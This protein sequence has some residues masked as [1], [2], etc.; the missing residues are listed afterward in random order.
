MAE[1][2]FRSLLTSCVSNKRGT[3]IDILRGYPRI[4]YL[5]TGRRRML[6]PEAAHEFILHRSRI[7]ERF[8]NYQQHGRCGWSFCWALGC[9][10][11]LSFHNCPLDHP[12]GMCA[13]V[14]R[15]VGRVVPSCS[16][17]WIGL[18]PHRGSNRRSRRKVV[19]GLASVAL[20]VPL[21]VVVGRTSGRGCDPALGSTQR[22]DWRC[23]APVWEP[24]GFGWA[25][26]HKLGPGRKDEFVGDRLHSTQNPPGGNEGALGPY[27]T[28]AG[29]ELGLAEGE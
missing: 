26:W 9:A 19:A 27:R 4:S 10:A 1:L 2:T 11:C 7:T 16:E 5:R 18:G 12:H 28:D 13:V 6:R 17:R 3:V 22:Q 24:S 23:C 15:Q 29:A 14:L 21:G 20:V 25:S 8:S